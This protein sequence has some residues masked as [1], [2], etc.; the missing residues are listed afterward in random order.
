MA[1]NRHRPFMAQVRASSTTSNSNLVGRKRIA[2]QGSQPEIYH[3]FF[4]RVRAGVRCMPEDGNGLWPISASHW[5]ISGSLV[6]VLPFAR[7][8]DSA[9]KEPSLRPS[10][11]RSFE[12]TNNLTQRRQGAKARKEQL[13]FF[14]APSTTLS[15]S[16]RMKCFC[17]PTDCFTASEQEGAKISVLI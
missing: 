16:R 3:L 9:L 13:F 2:N 1:F 17:S 15:V 8:Q 14:F 4:V 12:R 11:E 5:P 6:P 7:T 10:P